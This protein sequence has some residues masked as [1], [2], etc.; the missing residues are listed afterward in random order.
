MVAN[1]VNDIVG[2]VLSSKRMVRKVPTYRAFSSTVRIY[3]GP[4]HLKGTPYRF[5]SDP[6]QAYLL[7]Q[8]DSGNWNRFFVCAP[9]QF[10]GKT[11]VCIIIPLLRQA[12]G[13]RVPVGYGLPT[14]QDLDKAWVEKLRPALKD[15]GYGA[16]LPTM[17]PGARGGRGH[18]LQLT[19]PESGEAEG[20]IIFMAGGAIGSTVGAVLVDEIDKFRTS[21][22]VPLWADIED[23]FNR[24]NA[25]GSTAIR[26]GT[27]TIE[28]DQ[29]SII[30]PLVFEQGSGTVPH[31]RCP[32]C[33]AWVRLSFDALVIDFADEDT[34]AASARLACPACATLWT[35]DDRQASLRDCRFPHAGQ[36]VA[37]D[38][39][40]TGAAPKT[41]TLGLWWSAL[42]SPHTTIGDIARE[43]Y[44][45][46]LALDTRNDH[47]LLR[48]FWRYRR[49]QVYT[50][51]M[52]ED[53]APAIIT[54]GYLAA[55]S[56]AS[57]YSLQAGKEVHDE[58]GDSIH[59]AEKPA[60]IEFLTFTEDVQRGGRDAP[61]RNYF[62][63]QGWA[64]DRR[65]WDLAWGS[66]VAC[67]KGREP[68]E[69]ELHACLSRVHALGE[70]LATDYGLPLAQRGVDVGDRLPEI[71]RWLMR[72]TRWLAIRGV[73]ATRKALPGDIQ[74]VIYRRQQDGGWWLH[75]IDVHEM[76]QA[77][78]NGFLVPPGKPGAAHLPQ[79]IDPHRGLVPHYCATAL[80]SDGKSGL[81]W[82]NC[83]GD[84]TKGHP[85]QSTRHDLLDCRTYGC[86]LA[87]YELRSLLTRNRPAPRKY[88]VVGTVFG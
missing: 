49:C 64:A 24:A 15:S 67:P 27:G 28:D 59:V 22:G 17:G 10:G 1:A 78:Q 72:N 9:P 33:K 19:D 83:K 81:R 79:G 85:E 42:E 54:I 40:I 56:K 48:K 14:L 18:T 6:S 55:R 50:A 29:Q 65:S 75:E 3:A 4:A 5:G 39:S 11:L 66:L 30:L 76:R 63:L 87:E 31:P 71:R 84:R 23:L 34:A 21:S 26:I 60:G 82:S 77:A 12:I 68:S 38:G 57:T 58:D 20:Y 32:H 88:G 43:W 36:L 13:A 46:K 61:G 7:E 45:A 52:G 73:E 35:E 69:A 47:E 74:G 86:A 53:G 62:L 41:Q 8:F 80:I 16:H 37:D 70:R 2:S 25:Y 44:R 51:D